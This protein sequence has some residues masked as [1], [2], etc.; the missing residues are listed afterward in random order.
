MGVQRDSWGVTDG[1][2]KWFSLF[3]GM[4]RA[5]M[6]LLV[7]EF[8]TEY[9]SAVTASSLTSLFPSNP[10]FSKYNITV[11]AAL[12]ILAYVKPIFRPT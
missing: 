8:R 3:F 12:S 4:G 11:V 6:V 5:G 1:N 10:C 7:C 2:G 9:A